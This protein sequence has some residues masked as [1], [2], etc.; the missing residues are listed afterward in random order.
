MNL[1]SPIK[2]H[3]LL[4]ALLLPIH[5][6]CFSRPNALKPDEQKMVN[7]LLDTAFNAYVDQ[8]Y[9]KAL[10]NF[11]KVL[12]IDPDDKTAKTGMKRCRKKME[13]KK[14]NNMDSA[15]KSL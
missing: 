11:Q 6:Q 13:D 15:R 3:A 1:K 5:G 10:A 7:Q 14:A 9:A 2:K 8:D 4:L 12:Q